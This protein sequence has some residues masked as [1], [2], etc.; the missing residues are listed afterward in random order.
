MLLRASGRGNRGV[1]RKR[2]SFF[3]SIDRQF[4]QQD[5]TECWDQER[6]LFADSNVVFS[7][8]YSEKDKCFEMEN[9]LSHTIFFLLHRLSLLSV[10][11][12]EERFNSVGKRRV[13]ENVSP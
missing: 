9:Y 5:F 10:F 1:S 13:L 4:V 8:Y 7:E 11:R 12:R 2:A 6:V 3:F